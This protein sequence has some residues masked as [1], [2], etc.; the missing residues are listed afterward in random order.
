MGNGM[1]GKV[2]RSRIGMVAAA[3]LLT[4]AA[5]CAAN[6][7]SDRAAELYERTF[8]ADTPDVESMPEAVE[9]WKK[10]AGQGDSKAMYY[11][12][13]AYFNGVAGLVEADDKMALGLLEKAAE[14]GLP[15]AQ[16]S[17]GW[18]YESGTKVDRDP[19]RAFR[20][21]ESAARQGYT[22]AMS[23]LIRVFS[24]G[25]LGKPR[26][27]ERAKYWQQKRRASASR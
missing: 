6:V 18:Q 3:W 5:V 4:C 10:L 23:R 17:L 19:E 20:F 1:S 15:E 11:L 22:L 8:G 27:D 26:D 9:L 7:E 21:Y 16:F 12:S 13:A 2:G 14:N 24:E 25:E